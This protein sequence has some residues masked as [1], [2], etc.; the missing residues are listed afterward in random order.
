MRS[1]YEMM[2]V[3]E[4][5]PEFYQALRR[6]I[7]GLDEAK[8]VQVNQQTIAAL[9]N[10]IAARAMVERA[11]SQKRADG[12]RHQF[13]LKLPDKD[14][15]SLVPSE[16]EHHQAWLSV[17][18]LLN[19]GGYIA[20]ID[21][22]D[23]LVVSVPLTAFRQAGL[24]AAPRIQEF[25]AGVSYET[26]GSSITVSLVPNDL[27]QELT[28]LTKPLG[29]LVG[30]FSIECLG[31][32][33]M[34]LA[35]DEQF[36]L[37]WESIAEP[38]WFKEAERGVEEHV[39]HLA[40]ELGHK[41]KLRR[42]LGEQLDVMSPSHWVEP[43]VRRLLG[44]ERNRPWP[45]RLTANLQAEV[46]Q[47][48]LQHIS[49]TV[50]RRLSPSFVIAQISQVG[51]GPLLRQVPLE[52]V[53]AVDALLLL[54]E[55]TMAGVMPRLRSATG[56]LSNAPGRSGVAQVL[57]E[58]FD[59]ERAKPEAVFEAALQWQNAAAHS[60]VT[61]SDIYRVLAEAWSSFVLWYGMTPE[62]IDW[63]QQV[64][65]WSSRAAHEDEEAI[66]GQEG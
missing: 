38:G 8:P 62:R 59:A 17:R 63:S 21:Q 30:R 49:S 60:G 34:P 16:S 58:S 32:R 24:L 54:S 19:R 66:V 47:A 2:A 3:V 43:R 25:G 56:G 52:T 65:V 45:Q 44:W 33:W 27:R 10:T 13:E 18:A 50:D 31:G 42:R 28:K 22:L 4:D 53:T 6:A 64:P 26:S 20:R 55:W 51:R 57:A 7:Q 12:K 41:G 11:A 15:S 61:E 23:S 39:K 9:R 40:H 1:N 35:W 14:Y 29:K 48:I 5:E 46:V 37:H 36:R